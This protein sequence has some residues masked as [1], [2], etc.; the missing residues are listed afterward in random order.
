MIHQQHSD[1]IFSEIAGLLDDLDPAP[2]YRGL[3][4]KALAAVRE[5]AETSEIFLPIDLP[6]GVADALG[7]PMSEALVAGAASMLLWAGADL[8]DDVADGELGDEWK[9]VSPSRIALVSTNLLSTLP[10]LLVAKWWP[11]SPIA[12]DYSRAVSQSLFTMSDGQIADLSSSR[13]VHTIE[14]YLMLVGRKTGA[15]LALFA[16]TPAILAGADADTVAG[17]ANY[18]LAYGI[19]S[20]VYSDTMSTV[21]DGP[22]NDLFQGKRTLPVLHTLT[23]IGDAEHTSFLTDLDKAATGDETAVARAIAWMVRSG[24]IVASFERV[25]LQRYRAAKALPVQLATLS[26]DH[27]LQRLMHDCRFL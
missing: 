12:A 3:F 1:R 5:A 7:R 9:D 18:G 21:A 24:S 19:M 23:A 2:A 11:G 13:S 26:R 20:Q 22:R 6:M 10:H 25:E 15:E 27:A 8:M 16:S 14:D 4:N 17:W